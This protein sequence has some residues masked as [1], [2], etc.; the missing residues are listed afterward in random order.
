[1][2][3]DVRKRDVKARTF[4]PTKPE[5]YKTIGEIAYLPKYDEESDRLENLLKEYTD[6]LEKKKY[7]SNPEKKIKKK[8]MLNIFLIQRKNLKK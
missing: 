2:I 1:M 7:I 5:I 8:Q 6:I 3:Q 4:A